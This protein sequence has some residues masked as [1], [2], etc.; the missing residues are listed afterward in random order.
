MASGGSDST[1][2]LGHRPESDHRSPLTTAEPLTLPRLTLDTGNLS[3]DECL[4]L[5]LRHIR[6]VPVLHSG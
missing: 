4:S 1:A 2:V 6:G 3:P 5:A